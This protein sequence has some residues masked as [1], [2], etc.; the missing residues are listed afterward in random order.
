MG[1]MDVIVAAACVPAL[2]GLLA[3]LV[4]EQGFGTAVVSAALIGV[5][6]VLGTALGRHRVGRRRP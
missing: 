4:V 6:A 1:Q 3:L 5:A 2:A